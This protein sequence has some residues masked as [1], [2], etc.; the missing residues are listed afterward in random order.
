MDAQASGSATHPLGPSHEARF[1][2]DLKS[3][4][5]SARDKGVIRL[6][7][8]RLAPENRDKDNLRNAETVFDDLAR[9]RSAWVYRLRNSDLMVVSKMRNRMRSSAPCSNF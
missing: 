3:F 4:D 2:D 8:S 9:R 1:L 6:H 7:L 5:A